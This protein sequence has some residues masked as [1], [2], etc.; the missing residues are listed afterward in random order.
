MFAPNY[1]LGNVGVA[2]G[3][4][5]YNQPQQVVNGGVSGV[6]D[7]EM[8]QMVKFVSWVSF[9]LLKLQLDPSVHFEQ[10]VSSVLTATRLPKSTILLGLHYLSSRTESDYSLSVKDEGEVFKYLIV[11]LL[12]GNKFNDDNTFRNKS[13]SEATGLKLELLNNMEREWLAYC[14]WN[15]HEDSCYSVVESCWNTWCQRIDNHGR[16]DSCVSLMSTPTSIFS[17][18]SPIDAYQ[19]PV[20]SSPFFDQSYLVPQTYAQPVF[21]NPYQTASYYSAPMQ[22]VPQMNNDYYQD[23]YRNYMIKDSYMNYYGY[24]NHFQMG[25]VGVY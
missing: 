11:S 8:K 15:L 9:S 21:E 13:W 6:L 16:S 18:S 1:Y 10:I 3:Y 17:N 25:Q 2:G 20:N 5:N 23:Y 19:T 12:L 14:G 24:N 22:S 4:C 7:Y